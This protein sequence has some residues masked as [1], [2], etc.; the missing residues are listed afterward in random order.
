MASAVLKG[1]INQC[2]H[3]YDIQQRC[4]C[5][6]MYWIGW[7]MQARWKAWKWIKSFVFFCLGGGGGLWFVSVTEATYSYRLWINEWMHH[8]IFCTIHFYVDFTIHATNPSYQRQISVSILLVY[9]ILVMKIIHSQDHAW[10]LIIRKI[11]IVEKL[12]IKQQY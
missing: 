12:I 2:S 5:L 1:R 9:S 3:N 7:D 8:Y 10:S 6:L 4:A 11:N